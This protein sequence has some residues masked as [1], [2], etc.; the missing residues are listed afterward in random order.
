ML[1]TTTTLFVLT[2]FNAPS[3]F[4]ESHYGDIVKKNRSLTALSNLVEHGEIRTVEE[5]SWN[6]SLLLA[7]LSMTYT[8][9]SQVLLLPSLGMIKTFNAN[10]SST[11]KEL[12]KYCTVSQTINFSSHCQDS[13]VSPVILSSIKILASFIQLYILF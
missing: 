6:F 10:Q 11:I 3:F 4:Q 2:V 1:I 12:L 9:K 7:N 5:L 8:D 13:Q